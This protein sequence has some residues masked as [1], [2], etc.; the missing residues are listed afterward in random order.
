[1]SS[2]LDNRDTSPTPDTRH[3]PLSSKLDNRDTSPTNDTRHNP[4]SSKLD[5]QDTSPTNDTRHNPLSSKLDNR[6]TSPTNDTRHNPLSSKLDN[7][8]T[9]PTNDTRHNPLSSKLDNRD[10]SP[11]PDTRHNPL[12][13]KLDNHP[14]L[15]IPQWQTEMV[16]EQA[17]PDGVVR[18]GLTVTN[19]QQFPTHVEV[20]TEISAILPRQKADRLNSTRMTG[21][22]DPGIAAKS[23]DTASSSK[24]S[25]HPIRAKIVVGA[26]GVNSTVR[27]LCGIERDGGVYIQRPGILH[28]RLDLSPDPSDPRAVRFCMADFPDTT[29][30]GSDPV[31]FI[32]RA[33]LTE[34]F[35][36][37]GGLRR[38]VIND[39]HGT[40]FDL[41]YLISAVRERTGHRL[42]A[43]DAIGFSAFKV[44]RYT[45]RRLVDRRVVLLGDAAH[46]MSPIGG[47]GMNLGWLNAWHLA[48]VLSEADL[49]GAL[50]SYELRALKLARRYSDRAA[51]NTRMGIPGRSE[52]LMR[53]VVRFLLAPPIAPMLSRR[54]TMR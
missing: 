1:L 4:L 20:E 46:V 37:P 30:F 17:L 7:Q 39:A 13:S 52:W 25:S 8:D 18:R 27:A 49:T 36:L 32:T 38:W 23:T 2:K 34:S 16:L 53:Q 48:D 11:T 14:V 43:D 41:E 33:G 31:V 42:P 24:T 12:S 9:S 6:D 44:Y 28:P 15:S 35:P 5:N 10:T 47:Q 26:D 45:A 50:S 19:L 22:S 51:F 3:N 21:N 54:F 29:D 40:R